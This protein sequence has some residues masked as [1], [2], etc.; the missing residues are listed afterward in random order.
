[1]WCNICLDHLGAPSKSLHKNPRY[2]YHTPV[3][4]VSANCY[5]ERSEAQ[6]K[7]GSPSNSQRSVTLCFTAFDNA[8]LSS[9][10]FVFALSPTC[11]FLQRLVYNTHFHTV[12]I[13]PHLATEPDE[14]NFQFGPLQRQRFTCIYCYLQANRKRSTKSR[15]IY[16][17][18]RTRAG[19]IINCHPR[20]TLISSKPPRLRKRM[21]PLFFLFQQTSFLSIFKGTTIF[22][23]LQI[24]S[25]YITVF[26]KNNWL[27]IFFLKLDLFSVTFSL[28]QC[29]LPRSA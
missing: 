16:R 22:H 2:K 5:P 24:R 28:L 13:C 7:C 11:E 26:S 1:M 12:W 20:G 27:Q 4:N 19:N 23:F 17:Q 21:S 18:D 15:T 14:F 3:I 25:Y 10:L 8:L 9:R 6:K 29:I